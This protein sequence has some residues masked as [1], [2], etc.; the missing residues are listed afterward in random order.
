LISAI[1]SWIDASNLRNRVYELLEHREILLTALDD[2]ARMEP[3]SLA[4]K[5]A[6]KTLE[7]LER[8]HG[9]RLGKFDQKIK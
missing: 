4:G 1:G 9:V 5:H 7:L 2:V 6:Q 3:D 8:E